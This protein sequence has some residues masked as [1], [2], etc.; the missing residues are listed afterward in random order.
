MMMWHH[1]FLRD[2][3][4]KYAISFWPLSESQVVNIAYFCKICVSL[5]AFVSGYGLYLSYQKKKFNQG[6][7]NCWILKRAVKTLSNY[8]II[9]VLS[10]IICTMIDGRPYQIYGFEKSIFSGAWNA[11]IDFAGLSNLTGAP[12]LIEDWW[13]ISAALV[14]I[15][16]LPIINMAID[17]GGCLC[18]VGGILIFPRMCNGF[19]GGVHFLS[20]LPIFCFGMI[21]AKYDL[22]AKWNKMW[23]EKNRWG[24][25][26]LG[27]VLLLVFWGVAY[28]LYYHLSTK[29]WWDVKYNF[30]PIV[31]ILL[32]YVVT[33][34]IPLLKNI[35]AFFGTH[36]TNIWL[37]H[38]FI[39]HI[40]CE[41]FTYGMRHFAL[42]IA[43]LFLNSLF[44]SIVIEKAKKAVHYQNL[45]EKMLQ[46]I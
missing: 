23:F 38:A 31:T 15:L 19:P 44:L 25:T 20:F 8:W 22:F 45:I 18:V 1:C 17:K 3:F 27:L 33:N 37:I 43:V 16:L 9:V 40:Y 42:I 24:K 46:K 5:F 34:L 4:E 39:R 26:I 32:C 29:I 28:K 7:T 14:F 35:L 2:R 30:I 13:Y 21:F 10:W 6:A 41:S 12:E 36:A 11:I